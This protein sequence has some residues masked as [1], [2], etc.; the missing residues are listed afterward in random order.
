MSHS[1]FIIFD[2]ISIRH[3]LPFVMSHSAF[4]TFDII[5]SQCF[6]LFVILSRSAFIT[7]VLMSFNNYLPLDILSFQRFFYYS[8][9]FSV[10]LL[11]HS[12]FR[13]STFFTV[14]VF[15]FNIL[16]VN[17]TVLTDRW[18]FNAMHDHE[19]KKQ[20]HAQPYRASPHAKIL[21]DQVMHSHAVHA[22]AVHVT[23]EGKKTAKLVEIS[24]QY[25]KF[26]RYIV[27]KMSNNNPSF[28]PPMDIINSK[29]NAANR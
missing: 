16:S 1:A 20:S 19:V 21:H 7:F 26:S 8:D 29:F 23:L 11:S 22:H 13:P 4:I 9:V 15:Y 14:G 28:P 2:I 5:S 25:C 10:D 3:F 18:R 17:L 12:P 6:L 24:K 27:W